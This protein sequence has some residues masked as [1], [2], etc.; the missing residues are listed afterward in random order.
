M[1]PY[2]SRKEWFIVGVTLLLMFL[3]IALIVLLA[4]M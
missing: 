3:C 4:N 1:K 2:M